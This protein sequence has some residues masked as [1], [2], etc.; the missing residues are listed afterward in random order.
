VKEYSFPHYLLFVTYFPHLIAGPVLHHKDMIPQSAHTSTYRI[1]W[2]NVATGLLLFTLGL[3][4]KVLWADTLAPFATAI[5]D[6]AQHG[7]A[8]GIL[9]TTYEAWSGAL[10]YTL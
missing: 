6:G 3:C 1:N 2:D 5:F 10:A 8:T 9:P 4:K 7:I